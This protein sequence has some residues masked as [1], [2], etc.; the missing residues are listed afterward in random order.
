MG[1]SNTSLSLRV[2]FGKSS[3]FHPSGAEGYRLDRGRGA[4]KREPW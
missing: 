2:T 1:E 3:T 4:K